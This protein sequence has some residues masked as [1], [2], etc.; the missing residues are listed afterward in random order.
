MGIFYMGKQ[1]YVYIMTN[2]RKNVLYTGVTSDLY[3]RVWQHKKKF[4]KGFTSK[5]NINQ[6][7]YYEEFDSSYDAIRREK[8]IK[9]WTR[10]KKEA[11][12][13]SVNPTWKD[14]SEDWYIN[15]RHSDRNEVKGRI[16][17]KDSRAGNRDPSLRSG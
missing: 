9:G 8:K 12:I 4:V 11:L 2:K 5:Y 7:M 6:L 10:E 1:Y 13:H 15:P 17:D 16:S 14:L 3:G